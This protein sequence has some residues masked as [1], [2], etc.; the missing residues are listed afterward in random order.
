MKLSRFQRWIGVGAIF[1]ASHVIVTTSLMADEPSTDAI[2]SEHRD[3][4]EKEV[5]PLL[6]KRCFECHGGSKA[7]GGLELAPSAD[8]RTLIRRLS[9]DLTGLPPTTEEVEAFVAD[10]SPDAY[11][12]LI[13][14]LLDSPQHGVHWG[15]R[16]LDVVRYADRIVEIY[17]RLFQ[18][19]P[20]D[21]EIERCRKFLSNYPGVAEEKWS[22][23]ARVFLANNEFLHVD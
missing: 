11:S 17:R 8:R 18:R 15:R 16:W 22:A 4:F 23:L 1:A 21:G 7:D 3:Y 14:R 10:E 2:S 5:R 9:Y 20:L 13:E 6:V 19:E 12:R